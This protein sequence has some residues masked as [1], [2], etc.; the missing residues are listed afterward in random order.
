M[1]NMN[2]SLGRDV[3][4]TE[5]LLSLIRA[6]LRLARAH[7]RGIML[8]MRTGQIDHDE[9]MNLRDGGD[10]HADGLVFQALRDSAMGNVVDWCG[11]EGKVFD[12]H[13]VGE[14]I[15]HALIDAQFEGDDQ[16]DSLPPGCFDY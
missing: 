16:P 12:K 3:I 9:D 6:E 7:Y 5:E 1:V 11:D 14:F 8:G 2:Q 10:V 15:R 13:K 4:T